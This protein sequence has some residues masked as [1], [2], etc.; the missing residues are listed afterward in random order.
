MISQKFSEIIAD[1]DSLILSLTFNLN[2]LL[3][4]ILISN[5]LLKF[6]R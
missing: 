4:I 2:P 1:P 5:M 6:S 3:I